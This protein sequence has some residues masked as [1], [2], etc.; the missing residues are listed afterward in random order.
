LL[1]ELPL[2]I[3]TSTGPSPLNLG[4]AAST[5]SAV[6][7]TNAES[8]RPQPAQ[9]LPASLPPII[10]A[11]EKPPLPIL[12]KE[13]SRP[14]LSSQLNNMESVAKADSVD[15]PTA[16]ESAV[17]QLRRAKPSP[18]TSPSLNPTN[19]KPSSLDFEGGPSPRSLSDQT[20]QAEPTAKIVAAAAPAEAE[21][22]R[23]QQRRP[24][25]LLEETHGRL[26]NAEL[27]V[28]AVAVNLPPTTD[29]ALARAQLAKSML[30]ELD[31]ATAIHL[32]WVMRDI[33]ANRAAITPASENDLAALV[34][35]GFV[36]I[37]EKRPTL[38]ALGV[39]AL[40]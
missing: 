21:G 40:D 36:E 25:F 28:K 6:P 22:A 11:N 39:L 34:E 35:L 4:L 10:S 32:R 37:R 1:A 38:T 24:S 18:T 23:P 9:S 17:M 8:A 14:T 7:Q 2:P 16:A 15:T 29:G 13:P 3:S 19:T 26:D 31:L 12:D 33:R 20:D 30:A 27:A 5:V